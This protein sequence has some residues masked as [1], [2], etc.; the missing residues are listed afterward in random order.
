LLAM[1]KRLV[2]GKEIKVNWATTSTSGTVKV[3]TSKHFHIFVGDLAPEID[4]NAIREAFSPFGEISE[5]KIAKFTDT[6]KP[7]GIL[8]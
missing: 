7:K 1:N 8:F 6:Q 3:D 4:Q 5:V 2:M